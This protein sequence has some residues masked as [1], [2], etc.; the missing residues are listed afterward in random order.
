MVLDW[1][2]WE[3]KSADL[4][5]NWCKVF[6][7]S[8]APALKIASRVWRHL[9]KAQKTMLWSGAISACRGLWMSR[10]WSLDSVRVEADRQGRLCRRAG[11]SPPLSGPGGER[12][13]RFNRRMLENRRNYT[14]GGT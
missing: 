11:F 1:R 9:L 12:R 5:P 6:C 14:D 4:A 8:V 3:F 13:S 10:W 2:H 7:W